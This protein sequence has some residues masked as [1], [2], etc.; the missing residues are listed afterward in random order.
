[1]ICHLFA[2]GS[3]KVPSPGVLFIWTGKANICLALVSMNHLSLPETM[4]DRLPLPPRDCQLFMTCRPPPHHCY[5]SHFPG[6]HPHHCYLSLSPRLHPHHCYLSL[7]PR[8]PPSP[9]LPLSASQVSTFTIATS[10]YFP[11]LHSHHCYLSLPP[12]PPPSPLLPLS[13]SQ[14]STLTT[15][16]CVFL[17]NLH[18]HHCYCLCLPSLHP[19]HFLS[20]PP[21]LPPSLLLP[22]P[23]SKASTLTKATAD[24]QPGVA[25]FTAG[26]SLTRDTL[27]TTAQDVRTWKLPGFPWSARNFRTRSPKLNQN[28]S[29]FAKFKV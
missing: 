22:V 8:P 7:S 16:T 9:L 29:R 21:E 15:A 17:Q 3:S 11:G 5:L 10:L 6:L 24:V 12:R 18:P 14:V 19:H 27:P 2:T 26:E 23:A 4:E 20:L 25:G 13:A 1:M 28:I